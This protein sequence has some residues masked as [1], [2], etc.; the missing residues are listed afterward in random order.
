MYQQSTRTTIID[1]VRK[2]TAV[3]VLF[4]LVA[5]AQVAFAHGGFEHVMGTVTQ[6][7]ADKVTV[8]TTGKKTAHVDLTPKTTY[9]RDNKNVAAGDM[10][11]GDRVVID[12]T[13][14]AGKLTAASIKLGAAAKPEHG[15][16]SEH[17]GSK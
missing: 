10:K 15:E 9:T 13:E 11:V 5:G 6:V 3:S 16:H 2:G 17:S 7:S 14:T 8:E 12:A 4:L 1:R